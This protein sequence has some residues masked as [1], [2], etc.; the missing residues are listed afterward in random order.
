MV[1]C[2]S[3]KVGPHFK[4]VGLSVKNCWAGVGGVGVGVHNETTRFTRLCYFTEKND[5]KPKIHV[6]YTVVN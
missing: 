5:F 1:F 3:V 6:C 4:G 2:T